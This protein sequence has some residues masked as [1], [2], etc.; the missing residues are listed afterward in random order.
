MATQGKLPEFGSDFP[1]L[2]TGA[3]ASAV[4]SRARAKIKIYNEL[5]WRLHLAHSSIQESMGRAGTE[6][7]A[8]TG[9]M[10]TRAT[11]TALPV[12]PTAAV[13][14]TPQACDVVALAQVCVEIL[15]SNPLSVMG[16]GT[17][18]NAVQ[19]GIL[20]PL[21]NGEWPLAAEAVRAHG[22]AHP[23]QKR[24]VPDDAWAGYVRLGA[25]LPSQ[26]E[27]WKWVDVNRTILQNR[28]QKEL[29]NDET[30]SDEMSD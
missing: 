21:R 3:T 20:A 30:S 14:A 11:P 6:V 29:T 9:A 10:P 12:W 8:W 19:R 7:P 1:V 22:R 27:L 25:Q 17:N 28:T 23:A 5:R 4:R 2:P 26:R 13:T 18:W 15:H 24:D 16:E